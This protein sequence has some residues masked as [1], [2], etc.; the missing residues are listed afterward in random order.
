MKHCNVPFRAKEYHHLAKLFS[1]PI[2]AMCEALQN[3]E[4]FDAFAGHSVEIAAE[5]YA[6]NTE[7]KRGISQNCWKDFLFMSRKWQE[8]KLHLP[9]D[10]TETTTFQRP[11]GVKIVRPCQGVEVEFLPPPKGKR[12]KLLHNCEKGL[13]ASDDNKLE[14][15]DISAMH[16]ARHA[17]SNLGHR[18]WKMPEQAIAVAMAVHN[19]DDFFAI[20]PTGSGKSVFQEAAQSSGKTVVVIVPLIMLIKGHMAECNATNID[21]AQYMASVVEQ[22]FHLLLFLFQLKLPS[23]SIFVCGLSFSLG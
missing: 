10:L 2:R 5:K 17:L 21:C 7:D 8:D 1:E 18:E 6:Q 20:L 9:R 4:A 19:R 11:T 15:I 23:L 13:E 16:R 12:I 14:K 3:G 22:V